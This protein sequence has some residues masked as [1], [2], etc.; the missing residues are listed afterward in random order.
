MYFLSFDLVDVRLGIAL[1]RCCEL[2]QI[3][4]DKVQRVSR[5]Q[6]RSLRIILSFVRH[7]ALL[8]HALSELP[9][10]ANWPSSANLERESPKAHHIEN[11]CRNQ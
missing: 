6:S 11:Y 4:T 1:N 2:S 7:R 3:A 8:Y 9:T 5:L 10:S